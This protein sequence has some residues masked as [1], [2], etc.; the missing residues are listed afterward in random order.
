[1]SADAGDDSPVPSS[2]RRVGVVAKAAS[3][4]A[5]RTAAELD[6]WLVRRGLEVRLEEASLRS[7]VD[8][9][10]PFLEDEDVDLVVVLGGDGTLLSVARALLRPVPILGVNMGSLGFLT[11]V[12]RAE[13]Y[14]ILVRVLAG[15]FDL[16]ERSL[17]RVELQRESGERLG[18]H[19]LND[20][21]IGKS[22]L[23]RI[24]EL[25]LAVDGNLVGNFRADGLIIST[26]TG[27]TAYNLS[28]G[29]PILFPQ[30]PVVVITPICPH[31]LSLR[32]LVLP[33]TSRI[34]VTLQ[35]E[36]EEVYL[37]LD[38]QEGAA[39]RYRDRV[40]IQRSDTVVRLVKAAGRTFYESL[41]GK[42][43]WGG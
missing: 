30:L 5:M 16:E 8:G 28:A 42:L 19:V 31:T 10:G 41:R 4:E 6:E 34:E 23:A 37:S 15:H 13:L 11:E 39:L 7:G 1:M 27:S 2:F 14:P 32:P 20:A 22:A 36:R 38:G 3:E 26:P 25:T 35:T 9:G 33:D 24:I 18:Y 43:R 12:N 29:G 17:L 40:A 21:V